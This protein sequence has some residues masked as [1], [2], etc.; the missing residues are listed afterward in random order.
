MTPVQT[1]GT[2]LQIDFSF[3]GHKQTVYQI[4]IPPDEYQAAE[5]AACKW[6]SNS[7]RGTYGRGILATEDDPYATCRV[8]ILGQVA[9]AKFLGLDTDLTYRHQGDDFDFLVNG[10]TVDLKTA[11]HRSFGVYITA[12]RN[13]Y[14]LPLTKDVYA[15]AYLKSEDRQNKTAVVVLV[16]WATK[17]EVARLT[18]RKSRYGNWYNRELE[19]VETHPIGEL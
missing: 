6:W 16:G 1:S 19:F 12:Q 10:K 9:L 18:P 14:D 15:A 4:D 17:E 2:E 3:S 5:A 11:S 7:K 13:G 8:G